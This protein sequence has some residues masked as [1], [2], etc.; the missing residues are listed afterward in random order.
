MEQALTCVGMG[1]DCAEAVSHIDGD[2]F[3]YCAAHGVRRRQH[4]KCRKLTPGEHK[5]LSRGETI[6]Y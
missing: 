3:T 5:R 4:C 1:H 6:R 2:G